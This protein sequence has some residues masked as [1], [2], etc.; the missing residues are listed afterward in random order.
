MTRTE[1]AVIARAAFRAKQPP[2][3]LRFWSKVDIREDN[4]CWPWMAA[5]RKPPEGYGAFWLNGKHQPSARIAWKLTYGNFPEGKQA[6]HRCD[7][8]ACC[9]PK[10]LF[11]G[12]NLIN[13]A[14]KVSKNRHVF[15]S[16]VASSKLK[17][18][19]VLKIRKL[20]HTTKYPVIAAMFNIT[21]GYV[22]EICRRESWRHL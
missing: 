4:E 18:R 13:N 1:A 11:I 7:N 14:D 15:G 21:V 3:E 6:L 20:Q 5:V 2:L 17:A 9:N 19:D 8:P 22:G 12:D 16:R 10:H